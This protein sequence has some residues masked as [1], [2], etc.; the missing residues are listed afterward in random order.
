MRQENLEMYVGAIY[1]LRE[2]FGASVP[3]PELQKYFG[4]S[5]ISI[6][7]MIQKL[8]NQDY[9]TYARYRGVSLT[10]KGE[11]VAVAL[12]RRHR[13][14]ERFLTDQL[15]VP[16]NQV[17]AIADALEHAA[18]EMVTDRLARLM[19]DPSNC[20]HGSLI[21]PANETFS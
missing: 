21:P 7:E 8:Q 15:N 13:I 1:R 3:L 20:P 11:Q 4:F 14:W 19:G 16:I 10:S 9:V 12:I 18:P 5:L 6:H 2:T 17:H